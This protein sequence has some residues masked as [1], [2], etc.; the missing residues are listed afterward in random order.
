MFINKKIILLIL[1]YMLSFNI[2]RSEENPKSPL[3]SNSES[4]KIDEKNPVI[5]AIAIE[6][7][8]LIK[9]EEILGVISLKVGDLLLEAKLLRDRQ[10]IFDLGYFT[11]PP[12]IEIKNF[13]E[14][15]KIN[16]KVAENPI[17][18]EII[19]I[20]NKLATNEKILSLME[21]K[22][23]KILN[24]KTL[25]ADIMEINNYYN[26]N[27]GYLLPN[28]ITGVNLNKEGK[29]TLNI[30]DGLI[31]KEVKITGN[32]VFS[33]AELLK[34]VRI[35]KGE[36]F[37]QN[38]LKEDGTKIIKHYQE[39][40]YL[41]DMKQPTVDFKSGLISLNLAEAQVE[42]VKI[43]GNKKTKEYFIRI[44]L[45]IKP[46]EILRN[47]RLK[48]DFERL[49]NLQIFEQVEPIL[50]P[51]SAPGKVILIWKIKEEEKPGIATFG[52][53]YGGSTGESSR[54]GLMGQISV[55]TRNLGGKGQ[56]GTLSWQ[57]GS[58]IDALNFSFYDPAINDKGNSLGF[59]FYNSTFEELRQPVLGTAPL[60]YALY[61]DHRGG[62][63]VTYGHPLNDDLKVLF[64]IRRE[65]LNISTNPKSNFR[66]IGL[67]A[68]AIN[69]TTLSGIYDT[70]DDVLNPYEGNFINASVETA[71]GIY[72]GSYTFSKWQ[73][74]I[75]KYFPLK[76]N[77][78][79]AM[80]LWGG[81]IA[82][83]S[84][85]TEYF[86]TGGT[87][88]IRAYSDNAF[89]GTKMI[90]LNLEFRFPI[91]KIQ[92]L[93]GAIFADAGNAWLP[94]QNF[95]LYKNAGV[96]LRIVFPKMGLGVIR[97]DYSFGSKG[98][99]TSIGIGQSF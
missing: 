69:S 79:L 28:H 31:V 15:V 27:L 93:N 42:E 86:Y 64:S 11:E 95:I 41:T 99:R 21:T 94:G 77:K 70:R 9:T 5:T 67:A 7:N 25:Y 26:E 92:M 90:L 59:S 55:G 72:K 8:Q 48:K 85:A 12:K 80:R 97:L 82:G 96:G 13:Q 88:T 71:G 16:F 53:G 89:F 1:I 17:V 46:G 30:Q 83:N 45:K 65:Q 84:P 58:F 73:G 98:G 37:N 34:L 50:E 36:L 33:E 19:L 76:N 4:I 10:A 60:E 74:E 23:D 3:P 61:D 54:S 78:T 29:L 35:K 49:R 32:T 14:G 20:D 87:D 75:R 24:T 47:R 68:G 57:R 56:S 81:Y 51:G 44:N 43:E 52:L 2:V 6:G 22:P 38:I 39:K 91:A 63:S 40:D 66:P 62:G 18:K